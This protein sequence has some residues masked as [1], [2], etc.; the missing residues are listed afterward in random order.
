MKSTLDLP[1]PI[2]AG[3]QVGTKMPGQKAGLIQKHP[4]APRGESYQWSERPRIPP[5]YDLPTFTATAN[6]VEVYTHRNRLKLTALKRPG[7]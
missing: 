7:P 1:V 4:S 2:K 5:H 3:K 6:Q